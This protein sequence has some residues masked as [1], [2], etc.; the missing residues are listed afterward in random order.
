M[1]DLLSI[2]A[3]AN[4]TRM[5]VIAYVLI[6]AIAAIDW[7]ATHYISLGFLYLFPII[8]VGGF[9]SRTSIISVALLCAILQEAFSNLPENEAVI[10]LLF[11][12]AGFVGTGL[13]I[14]EMIRNRRIVLK[15]SEE[16]EDQVKL[17]QDAE[18]QLRSL[19]ESSPAAIVTID[20]DGK[21]LLANEAAQQL[22]AP[23]ASPLQGQPVRSYL[24]S[25]QTVLKTQSSRI[26]RTTLQCTGQ[27]SDGEA[28]LAGVW[29]STYGTIAG[30]RLAAIIVDLSE[31]LRSREELS[32]DH[33][34]KNTRILMSTVAHEMRN[35]SSAVL[36]VHKNLSRMKELETNEDFRAL[37]RL[38]QSLERMSALE[39][40]S[41]P[42]QNGEVVELT[43]VLDELRI[44]IESTYHE[45]QISVQWDIQDALPLV[46]ADRYGL[47]QVFLNLAKNSQ[48]A[49][50]ST[51]T[52]RL[53][54]AACEENGQL[55]IRF[56]DTG[57]GIASPE[58]LFRPF[59][60]GAKS[61]G[62][63]LYV[64][65]VIMRSFG[66]DLT[67]EPGSEGSCFAVI[68][69]LHVA[70]EKVINA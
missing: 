67:H 51:E 2:Y 52:K 38:I 13:F 31:D 25:L 18:Q 3:P 63:G 60:R 33:L 23:G 29:F 56:E 24:P 55:V 8:I 42:T 66:G 34:L 59:Q 36:V 44:L 19:I 9:L 54:I 21:V 48:R 7:W 35:L 61:S 1:K 49:M 27:R 39:L 41:T 40:G 12:S 45:S 17:R 28:F 57:I 64:S 5:L 69:P 37:G 65:R 47:V 16:L 30:P 46:W 11:S 14:S 53:R 43:S 15:H 20:S 4:R 6:A 26:F 58:N 50:S 32:L 22:L 68:L 62:L 70:A 10:R